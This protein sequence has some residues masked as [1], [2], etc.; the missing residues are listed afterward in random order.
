MTLTRDKIE[1][2]AESAASAHR[3]GGESLDVGLHR[4]AGMDEA[5]DFREA[6]LRILADGHVGYALCATSPVTAKPLGCTERVITPL[7]R[8]AL[9]DDGSAFLL[10]RG[11]IG[12]GAR[13]CFVLA[14]PLGEVLEGPTGEHE[15]AD[16]CLACHL[17]LHIVGRRVPHGIPLNALTATADLGLE[18]VHV[19]GPWVRD[20]RP[21]DLAS[22]EV[23][24]DLDGHAVTRGRGSDTLGAPIGA[25]A[26]TAQWLAGRERRL[27]AGEVVTTGSCAGLV[28]IVPGQ[29]VRASFGD[30]GTVSLDL[31]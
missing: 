7:R 21:V 22:A 29:N 31:V 17:E 9:L 16:A 3:S 30:L 2:I 27:E 24:I 6:T 23:R 18:T 8:G 13:Y 28:R 26:W 25:V 11:I 19:L 4:L 20:G 14:H 10:P 1:R 5:E 15:A 12:V